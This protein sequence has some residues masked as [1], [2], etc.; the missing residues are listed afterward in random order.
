MGFR[1]CALALL[2]VCASASW[3]AT[4]SDAS[5]VAA[6]TSRSTADGHSYVIPDGWLERRDGKTIVLETP[7]RDSRVALIDVAAPDVEAAVAAAWAAYDAEANWPL[8]KADDRP[9]AFGW[10]QIRSFRYQL[11]A[12]A[13]R[14][15]M[16]RAM[17]HGT[18]WSV[19]IA[20]FSQAVFATRESQLSRFVQRLWPNGYTH[21]PES[22]GG[23]AAH[24][25][26]ATRLA[27]LTQFVDDAR[28]ALDV[29]GVA[30]GIVQD[31]RVLFAGGFGERELGRSGAVDA[32]TRFLTASITKPLTTLMLAK[33]VDADHFDWDTP[34]TDVFPD[35][36]VGDPDLTRRLKMKHLVCACTGMPRQDNELVFASEGATPA[37]IIA[38]LGRMQPTAA[39]GEVYQYSNP[40]AAAAGYVG[41][42]AL[43]PERELGAAYDAAMQE[44]VFDPLGM[45]ATTLDFTAAQRGN[46][47]APHGR[48]L[49]G[50]TVRASMDYNYASIASRPDGGAWSS[51]NDLLRYLRME[52]ADGRLP[53]GR[54]YIGEASLLARREPQ[55]LR[56][57]EEQFYGMGLKINRNQGTPILWH[58]GSMA[59][60]QTDMQW[61][62]EHGVGYVL[63]T[64][65]DAGMYLRDVFSQRL[66]EVLFDAKPNA[67]ERLALAVEQ[68]DEEAQAERES[69]VVPAD[70]E[71]SAKL[72][73]RYRSAELGDIEVE[74]KG[75]AVWFDFGIWGSEVATRRDSDG[76][77]AFVTTSPSVAGHSFSLIERKGKDAL[78]L[79]DG[80]REYVFTA[81]REVAAR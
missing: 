49:D 69:L 27:A 6:P 59:G 48:E 63:L 32:D 23:K 61:L 65:A 2:I 60:Y 9:A 47:A 24:R 75:N 16:A 70:A 25:L 46:F 15:V 19:L 66:L 43:Y 57:G 80:Q 35:F 13:G 56:G 4:A 76:S 26:D 20:D 55:V 54:R 50:T 31:G 29:P 33:L 14:L 45:R 39:L 73:G 17:R 68:L 79:R 8:E 37:S 52:L 10:E 78:L 51:V 7:E 77:V 71:A 28:R 41:A 5:S 67:V 3:T 74:R 62:P 53:D 81:V 30:L 38:S 44:L 34:V 72:V 12:S 11:P 40:I 22:F 58:G 42:H 18:R 1:T 21:V 36:R 64:N